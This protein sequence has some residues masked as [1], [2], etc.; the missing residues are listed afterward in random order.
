MR[1]IVDHA[2]AVAIDTQAVFGELSLFVPVN[3]VATGGQTDAHRVAGLVEGSG[4][5]KFARKAPSRIEH[6]IYAV[7]LDHMRCDAAHRLVEVA[8]AAACRYRRAQVLPMYEV[9][10][11]HVLGGFFGAEMLPDSAD[12]A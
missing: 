8:I 7:M 9:G 12:L 6:V 5:R 3:E 2:G 1:V 4:R 10:A 11:D